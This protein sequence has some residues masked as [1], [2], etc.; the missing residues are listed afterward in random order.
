MI[1]VIFYLIHEIC[2]WRELLSEFYGQILYKYFRYWQWTSMWSINLSLQ[3]Q[4]RVQ[5]GKSPT[6]IAVIVENYSFKATEK[7]GG[8]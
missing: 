4:L 6:P 1:K 7:R 3:Q 8:L 5:V 2:I